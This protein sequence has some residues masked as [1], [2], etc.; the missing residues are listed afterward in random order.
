M[1]LKHLMEW[2]QPWRFGLCEY[3]FIVI[4]LRSTL[5]GSTGYDPIFESN[6]T[7]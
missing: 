1:T 2:L 5:S 7:V 6:R 3:P 4:A